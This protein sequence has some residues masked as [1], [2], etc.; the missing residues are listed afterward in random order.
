[1][2][3][4]LETASRHDRP[5]EVGLVSPWTAP[6]LTFVQERFPVSCLNPGV[7][8]VFV[9]LG[10]P[11]TGW[12]PSIVPIVPNGGDQTVYLVVD[13]FGGL[14]TA[15]RETDVV[16]TDLETTITDLMSGQFSDPVRVVAF[17][18]AEHWAQDVSKDIALEIQSRSDIEG[19]DVPETLRDF[20]DSYAGPDR[21]LTL[22]LARS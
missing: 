21:Q 12:T 9:E 1:M 13:R 15:Y 10:M 20:A 3:P 17:N 11:R 7:A 8:F 5:I 2:R 22:R 4:L 16:R 18:T 14:G 19:H 6:G